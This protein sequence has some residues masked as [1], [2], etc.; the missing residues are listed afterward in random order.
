MKIIGTLPNRMVFVNGQALDPKPSQKVFNHSPDGFSW[1]YNGSGP[2]QLALALTIK[3]AEISGIPFE[4]L[5]PYYQDV[6]SKFVA[7]WPIDEPIDGEFDIVEFLEDMV[8]K[9]ET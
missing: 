6:K 2:A 3:A 8:G 1:G 7:T 4:E 5:R 9:V